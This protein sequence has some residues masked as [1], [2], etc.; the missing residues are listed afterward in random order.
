MST[1][2]AESTAEQVAAELDLTGKSVL[3]TGCNSGLGLET[4]RVLAARGARILGAARS[5]T[6]AAEA[7]ASVG[8]DTAPIACDLS[9]PASIRMAVEAVQEPVDAIIA[10]AGVMALQDRT[11]Q[12]GIEAHLF[13][14]H[15]GHFMLITG[16][17]DRLTSNGRVAVLS[18]GAHAYA[19]P[20]GIDFDDLRWDRTYAP[21]AAYGQSKLAN[22]LFA[23]ELARRLPTG[24]TA[25]ALHPGVIQT[26]L[27]RHIPGPAAE[28]M[29]TTMTFKTIPQGAATQVFVAVHP[30]AAGTTGAYFADCE[31]R[32]PTTLACDPDLGARLW[33][34]TEALVNAL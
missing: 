24:Q 6:K 30:D 4:L 32:E 27:W 31:V 12:H 20:V 3:I 5:L 16:L 17:V 26:P 15:V 34:T 11:L 19:P 25:N 28:R 23:K 22:I 2:T 7:C 18:S 33:Q 14:N 1:F 29:K 9:D 10:N 8:G 13:T 21:W